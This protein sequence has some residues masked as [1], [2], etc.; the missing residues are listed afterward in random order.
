MSQE[1][2]LGSASQWFSQGLEHVLQQQI[3]RSE[4]ESMIGTNEVR[5]CDCLHIAGFLHLVNLSS[6]TW[7]DF[8][9]CIYLLYRS[10]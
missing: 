8:A 7:L 10:I 1:V 6:K 2:S 3:V 4:T 9:R 5:F